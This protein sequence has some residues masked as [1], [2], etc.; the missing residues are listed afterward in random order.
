MKDEQIISLYWKRDEHAIYYT[1][2]KYGGYCNSIAFRI[3]S[4][5]EDTEECVNDTYLHVWNAIP[6]TRPSRFRAFIGQITRNLALDYRRKAAAKK[7]G[8]GAYPLVLEDL[9]HCLGDGSDL[10]QWLMQKELTG[11]INDFL[12]T[13]SI[14][15]RRVFIQRYWYFC[16]I[17]EIAQQHGYSAAKVTSMLHRMRARFRTYLAERGVQVD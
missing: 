1:A 12:H 4:N 2:Q 5:Q 16:S 11:Y 17:A 14:P 8:A 3:L 10:E 6:P 13:L 15:Q 9:E 7:R